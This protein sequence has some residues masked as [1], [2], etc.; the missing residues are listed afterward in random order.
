MARYAP[1]KQHAL[2]IRAFK[3]VLTQLPD[4]ELHTWEPGRCAMRWKNRWR[5]PGYPAAS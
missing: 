2:L 5:Q 3:R 1:E 4:A